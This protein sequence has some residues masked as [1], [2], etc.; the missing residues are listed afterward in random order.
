M[1]S[2]CL[3]IFLLSELCFSQ[4][5]LKQLACAADKTVLCIARSDVLI[6]CRVLTPVVS[7]QHLSSTSSV[8]LGACQPESCRTA[9]SVP[10]RSWR[11]DVP[12]PCRLGLERRAAFLQCHPFPH[13]LLGETPVLILSREHS[14]EYQQKKTDLTCSQPGQHVNDLLQTHRLYDT[15]NHSVSDLC[16]FNLMNSLKISAA[17]RHDMQLIMQA[18]C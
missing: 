13:V 8:S 5:A 4:A 10:V 17:L 9:K 15:R 2:L 7:T 16:E 1:A 11:C 18:F 6:Q 3:W 12:L 14:Q